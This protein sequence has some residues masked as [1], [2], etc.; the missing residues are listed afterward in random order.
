MS[1]D[2][3]KCPGNENGHCYHYTGDSDF[4]VYEETG[5]AREPGGDP[6]CW[7]GREVT[8]PADAVLYAYPRN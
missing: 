1:E 8:T 4:G 3:M 6:C 5:E 2:V 7:C